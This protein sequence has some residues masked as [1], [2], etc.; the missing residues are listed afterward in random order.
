M[1]CIQLI[2]RYPYVKDL[3]VVLHVQQ[4]HHQVQE[5]SEE[6]RVQQDAVAQNL[7]LKF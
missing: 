7:N 3:C 1:F 2:F 4:F 6:P 5:L